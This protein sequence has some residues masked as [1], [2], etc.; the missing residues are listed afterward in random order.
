MHSIWRPLTWTEE[1]SAL[2]SERP[3]SWP[4]V[5][6]VQSNPCEVLGGEIWRHCRQG[7]SPEG[8]LSKPE[9]G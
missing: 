3:I 7:P 8:L 9:Y 5:I 4:V 2:S 6:D 1:I